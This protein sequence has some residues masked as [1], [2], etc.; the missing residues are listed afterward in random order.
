MSN[1]HFPPSRCP[2]RV[3]PARCLLRQAVNDFIPDP[4]WPTLSYCKKKGRSITKIANLPMIVKHFIHFF[5]IIKKRAE[6]PA[7]VTQIFRHSRFACLPASRG[8][9]FGCPARLEPLQGGANRGTNPDH[10]LRIDQIQTGQITCYNSGQS[11]FSLQLTF[12][13]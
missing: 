13:L 1:K 4:N 2:W 7:N 11:T 10:T 3:M 8:V 5:Q 6:H 12:T 9:I